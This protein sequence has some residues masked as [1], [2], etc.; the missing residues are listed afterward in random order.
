MS[1]T[2]LPSKL[3]LSVGVG[4]KVLGVVGFCLVLLVAVAGFS[5]WQMSQIGH[6]IEGI[7]E[8]DLPLTGALTKVTT[9]QLEQAI[10][11]ERAL[12][13]SGVKE[14]AET[15]KAEFA[16][17]FKKFTELAEKV[18]HEI[19]EAEAIAKAAH[20]TADTQEAR[21][22]FEEVDTQLKKVEEEHKGFDKHALEAFEHV[23]AGEFGKAMALLPT[24]KKEEDELNHALEQM[25]YK[26]EGFTEHAAKVAEEHE[27]FALKVLIALSIGAIV[28]GLLFSWLLVRRAIVGPLSEIVAGLAA[29][30]SDDMSVE[31]K[32]HSDDEIGAVAKA[33]ATFKETLKRAKELE[34]V[35]AEQEKKAAEERKRIMNEMADQFDASVGEV[36]GAVASAA[37]E[38]NT[39]AQSMAG[40]SEETSSQATSVAAASEEAT[41][42]VNAVAAASQEMSQSI[43]EINNQ[44]TATSKTSQ[45][46]VEHTARTHEQM[47]ALAGTT[48]K[49]SEVI[50]MI[51]D[52]A[53]Q[54]NLLALNATIES[55]RAGEAGKGFAVVAS[56]VKALA[57]E[58][59]KA[60]EEIS[61]QIEEV[62][63]A[64]HQSVTSIDDISK[65][66][67]QL[68]EASGAIA[69][70]MEEQG[71]TTQ[72]IARN[73]QEAASGTQEVSK[74][75][76]GVTTASQE[77][78]ASA[79]QVLSAS[80]EL[81]Q[82][83]E[84]L[85]TE[86]NKFMAQ[87]R[88]A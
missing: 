57:N 82:Q 62:Q 68:N 50:A 21:T 78:G 58:T 72:E 7:A 30:S 36:I 26:V 5:I 22:L 20:D 24:I 32:V 86:V 10:Y 4:T 16:E 49:I 3:N 74:N 41:A 42:N 66:I 71:A 15:A 2:V 43:D 63:S 83:S 6:E 84:L 67:S 55:A 34:A 18:D 77:A 12:R 27:K 38:L 45:E 80:E 52:I 56:E 64:T 53:E 9:H 60:T 31:L 39:A 76:T 8:R 29:L 81:S 87:V 14:D 54:T 75:I 1:L 13:S 69:A 48:D 17:A 70:A 25:L 47:T 88:A 51:S 85:K 46:A 23:K 19:K 33:Y 28:A 40:I 59:A 73:V 65:I 37:T 44:V 11:L 61:K 35:Q 79:S